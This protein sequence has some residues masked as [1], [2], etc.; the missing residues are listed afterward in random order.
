MSRWSLLLA[1]ALVAAGCAPSTPSA[2]APGAVRIDTQVVRSSLPGG[3]IERPL[4]GPVVP[5]PAFLAA[6][7]RG[8]RTLTGQPGPRYWT[9]RTDY[10]LR[11]GVDPGAKR[12]QG[13]AEIVY[14]NRSPVA[15]EELHVDL[16]LNLHAP[17]VVRGEPAEVTGGITVDRVRVDGAPVARGGQT[18]SRY[19]VDGT[20]MIIVPAQPVAPGG[21]ARIAMD[22]GYAVPQA[23]AG[24]RMGYS[25]DDLLFLAYGYPTM[26]V[27]DDINGWHPDSFRGTAEFYQDF[28]RFDVTVE[29]PPQWLVMGTGELVNA[30]E[31]L[32]PAV[33]GRLR[34]AER[35]DTVVH[36][37]T[38]ADF[39]RV[40]APGRAGTL[41]WRFVA[42]SVRDV[43]F[44]LTRASRWD[45]MRA[46]VGDRDGDGAADF[47]R[48]DAVWRDDRAPRWAQVA[49]YA[50][51]SVDFF[52]RYT[53]IPYPWPHMTAV[54]G[55]DIIGG[56]MEYPMMTLIGPY[57]Q[58]GDTALYNVTAHEI[59]HMWIPMIVSTDE[60]RFGWMDEGTTT[61]QENQARKEFFPGS[62]P[63]AGDR[64]AYLNVARA[65]GEGEI[66]RW[67][68]FHN[69]STAY[70]AA[71]YWKPGTL[72]ATL[73]EVLGEETFHRAHRAFLNEWKYKHPLPWD[74]W[75]TFERVSGRDLDWFWQSWYGTTWTLDHA[76]GSV[77]QSG[78]G[79][80]IT[81]RDLS[82]VP[83]PARLTV[84]YADGRTERREVPVE[85][86]L[87][88]A[89]TA[90]V[91]VPGGA[92]RV[93]IDA[94]NA[95][96]DVNRENNVWTR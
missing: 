14:H 67:S 29:A 7:A 78:A 6:V 64:T 25:G 5:P 50:R 77:T 31:V 18:G 52:S 68:D 49:R 54:E 33:L 24:A 63:E 76:V 28:G 56:G 86:W 74:M 4:L 88:G 26:A 34:A 48:V 69:T 66:T 89:R 35:S 92:T 51:H 84:T 39:G 45:A 8:T 20:R 58:A 30:A 42:D 85:T 17:G 40:T 65:A 36:V 59:S 70:V 1:G 91:T 80:S 55:T 96:P 12:V 83:M 9:N 41:R 72:L 22:F 82:N 60:R 95:F 46:P 15:L 2:S 37:V 10:T 61:F 93:E 79:T 21:T 47:A 38:A 11:F 23:G 81:V 13:A 3:A 27:F 94:E 16:T 44:S 53:G 90:T 73:R 62:D 57:T 87:T 75:N 71:S 19:A 32:A 43:A